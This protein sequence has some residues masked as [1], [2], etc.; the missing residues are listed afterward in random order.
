MFTI[1]LTQSMFSVPYS[2]LA[3]GWLDDAHYHKETEDLGEGIYLRQLYG[4]GRVQ[5]FKLQPLYHGTPCAFEAVVNVGKLL[6]VTKHGTIALSFEDAHTVIG[7]AQGLGLRF[8]MQPVAYEYTA[9]IDPRHVLVNTAASHL[10]F[11][12]NLQQGLCKVDAPYA[13]QCCAHIQLDLLPAQRTDHL[14]FAVEDFEKVYQAKEYR[15]DVEQSAY[16]WEQ[17]FDTF[18]NQFPALITRYRDSQRLGLYI[19]WSCIVAPKGN[20][21]RPGV[22]MSN[23]WMNHVWTWDSAINSMGLVLG[24]PELAKDQFFLPF[25]HQTKEGLLPDY[26]NPH[27]EMWNFT[28][29]PI[30]GIAILNGLLAYLSDEECEEAAAKMQLQVKYWIDYMDNDCDGIAQYNHGNDCGWDNCTSFSVGPPVEGP[31][32]TCYLIL[33][34]HALAQ[35]A[36]RLNHE[37][38]QAQW[39]E[40]AQKLLDC[41]LAHSWHNEHFQVY[42]SGTHTQSKIGD[43]FYPYMP[44][45]LGH[46]LPADVY[47]R[48]L[49]EIKQEGRFLT[50]F[51]LAS[52]SVTSPCYLPDGYW[53]GPIWPPVMLLIVQGI[54]DGGD[55][56][57]A[58]ELA[59]RFCDCV[60]EN[61]FAENFQAQ[62]G[63][64]LRDPAHTWAASAFLV[65]A[66][67]YCN[68]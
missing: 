33:Q 20:L 53:R 21:K 8:Q 45:V 30:H 23:N 26:V 42:Q 29:P 49:A 25:D 48:L 39:K 50:P 41:L 56:A 14:C 1:P 58:T 63:E 4:I 55:T 9:Q 13:E 46:Y 52:E 11:M 38:E 34:M 2:Y 68:E 35:M 59:N 40:R 61:G 60:N 65:L 16:E 3:I 18:A 7:E 19:L 62:T 57:F 44:L 10:Q 37:K 64:A 32:L 5:C 66:N 27:E 54:A 67:R 12:F 24:A 17:K 47:T 28:K 51:G 22:L 31:D 43:S 36:A 6:L 15:C